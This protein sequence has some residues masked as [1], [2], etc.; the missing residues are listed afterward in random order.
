MSKAAD[1]SKNAISA[2]SPLSRWL[3][4]SDVIRNRLY[5]C[6][7]STRTRSQG[8]QVHYTHAAAEPSYDRGLS[9]LVKIPNVTTTTTTTATTNVMAAITQLRGHF[10]KSRYTR[11][12][13]IEERRCVDS[14]C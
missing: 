5:Q 12:S 2:T 1:K 6:T 13:A 4:R 3:I 7:L 9:F 10:T 8:G 14:C 11:S